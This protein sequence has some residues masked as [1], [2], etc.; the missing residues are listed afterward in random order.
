[1]I[2]ITFKPKTL[3]LEVKGHAGQN[4]KGKDIVCSAISALF[5]TLAQTLLDSAEM[6]KEAPIVK[7]EEGNG[8][9]CCSPKVEYEGNVAT[10]YR[11]I[12]IGMQMVAEEYKKFVKF[13]VMGWK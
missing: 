10:I 11:T 5:Y 9:I 13:S 8:Y 7:N 6:L 1:M 2:E 12:L 3:E 4:E